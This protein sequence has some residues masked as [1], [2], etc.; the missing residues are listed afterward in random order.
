MKRYICFII[1]RGTHLSLHRFT[2]FIYIQMSLYMKPFPWKMRLETLNST[3]IG[4]LNGGEILVNC[5]FK[6]HTNLNLNLYRDIPRN[7]NP[8]QIS[9]PLCT[10]RYRDIWFSRFWLFDWNLPSV[11]DFDYHG[12]QLFES[13]FPR[14]GQYYCYY[15]S[16][17]YLALRNFADHHFPRNGL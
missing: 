3:V 13:H 11:Q 15:I 2:E 5:K 10:V 8:I 7:S 16:Q 14:N 1:S 9:I 6:S 17:S 12:I 4:I